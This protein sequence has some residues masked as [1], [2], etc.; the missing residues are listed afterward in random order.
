VLKKQPDLQCCK[1][2]MSLALLRLGRDAEAE[3][4]LAALLKEAPTEDAVLQAMSIAFKELQQ[5]K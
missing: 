3:K 2:L 4:I 1:G 5:S